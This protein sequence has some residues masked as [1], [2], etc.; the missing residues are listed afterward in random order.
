MGNGSFDG[1]RFSL[2]ASFDFDASAA[3]IQQ[4]RAV[5][6]A[7]SQSLYFATNGQMH[8]GKIIYSN[9]RA[10]VSIA[11]LLLTNFA[12]SSGTTGPIVPQTPGNQAILRSDELAHPGVI[13]HELGHYLFSLKEEY[14]FA[15]NGTTRPGSCG[16]GPPSE[17]AC[18]MQFS[19]KGDVL[20]LAT[21]AITLG[22]IR[23]F[24]C[25]ANHTGQNNQQVAHHQSCWQTIISRWGNSGTYGQFPHITGPTGS[26]RPSGAPTGSR[27]AEIEWVEAAGHN[28]VLCLIS[29]HPSLVVPHI[30]L[31]RLFIVPLSQ[32]DKNVQLRFLVPDSQGNQFTSDLNS[33][34]DQLNLALQF[35]VETLTVANLYSELDELPA[36]N[37][38]LV[39][40]GQPAQPIRN[41]LAQNTE[42]FIDDVSN[43]GYFANSVAD[44]STIQNV[45]FRTNGQ[46]RVLLRVPSAANR[47]RNVGQYLASAF[48]SIE[49][50]GMLD[51]RVATL[52][53]SISSEIPDAHRHTAADLQRVKKRIVNTGITSA[54]MDFPVFVERGAAQVA[55][56]VAAPSNATV[57]LYLVKP[58]GEVIDPQALAVRYIKQ[59]EYQLYLLSAEVLGPLSGQWTMRLERSAAAGPTPFHLRAYAQ[60]NQIRTHLRV[61]ENS[62]PDTF[63]LAASIRYESWPLA[64]LKPL[65]RV[66][67]IAP[68]GEVISTRLVELV[69]SSVDDAFDDSPSYTATITRTSPN[70]MSVRVA[71]HNVGQAMAKLPLPDPD[72]P[73]TDV[74]PPIP[75]FNRVLEAT[76]GP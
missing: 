53:N 47:V 24:C 68:T 51:D 15:E 22:Q 40:H 18:I 26:N 49:H 43:T 27:P 1:T 60:N 48:D 13:L 36:S 39:L 38:H 35:R 66:T 45:I 69:Q 64:N 29:D 32:I 54:S 31:L 42:Q 2:F 5:L 9:H 19:G 62:Q 71:I 17:A 34:T 52:P 4:W 70:L 74:A 55:F 28:R 50:W 73:A 7:A 33:L 23:H 41:F 20:D 57:W 3:E 59:E 75:N 14:K 76:I 58:N 65:A 10:G 25:Q 30:D 67:E 37:Q 46:N 16:N 63:D 8:I 6:N 44:T 11:D 56:M 12:G 61:T 21:G 72:N